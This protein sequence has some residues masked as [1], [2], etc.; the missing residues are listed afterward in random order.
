MAKKSAGTFPIFARFFPALL[1]DDLKM[2]KL[3]SD[4]HILRLF[5]S[6]MQQW[7]LKLI[8]Y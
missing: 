8:R 6:I 3:R 2:E 4:Y 1:A 7:Q 5:L